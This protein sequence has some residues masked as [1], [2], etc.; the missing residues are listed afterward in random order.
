MMSFICKYTCIFCKALTN[1]NIDL[2]ESCEQDL[3]IIKNCCV[4]C[5]KVLG[6]D[7]REC[8]FCLKNGLNN[9]KTKVFFDYKPPID[10]I[11]LNFK[12]QNNLVGGRVLS[13][14][15]ANH[16]DKQCCDRVK[17]E[18]IIPVPLHP[19]RLRVRGYNQ[20][21]EISKS[22]SRKLNIPI[23]KFSII[24]KKNTKAQATLSLK[25]RK[26]NLKGAFSNARK[27]H[28]KH[29]AIVDD[30]ITTGNTVR[31]LCKLLKRLGVEQIDVW[32]LAKRQ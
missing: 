30:V 13:E 10:Q 15:L 8:G 14:L 27:I 2:C 32:C 28:Y 12:F 22:I 16:I 23:D 26:N 7:Q 5:G 3:P 19:K 18:V 24:R 9:I 1:R 31:E 29:V 11:I 25:E 6:V 21:L 4:S 20:A 17:P